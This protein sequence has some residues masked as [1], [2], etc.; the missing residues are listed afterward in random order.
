MLL[1]DAYATAQRFLD[2]EIRAQH[3]HEIVIHRC[4]ETPHA[5]AFS[6]NARAYLESGNITAALAGNGPVIVPKD[7]STPYFGSVLPQP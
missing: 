7:G 1:Q 4:E 5:W 6:Y 3:N 2:D